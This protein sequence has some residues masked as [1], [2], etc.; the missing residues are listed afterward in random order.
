MCGRPATKVL[1]AHN[2]DG[3]PVLREKIVER[4]WQAYSVEAAIRQ[5]LEIK[6][7]VVNPKAIR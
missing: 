4:K 2:V 3:Q 5:E 1:G 6:G 7:L